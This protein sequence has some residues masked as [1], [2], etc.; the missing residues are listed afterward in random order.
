MKKTKRVMCTV[1]ALALTLGM[2]ACGGGGS[3]ASGKTKIK[4]MNYGGGIGRVWLD[5][6]CE[7]FAAANENTE[8]EAGKK[9]VFFEI[10]HNISTG[11]ETMKSAG[12]NIY[13]DEATGSI[14]S[15]A[16]SESL[17][18]IND[19][20][21]S[22]VDGET[23]ESKIDV[24]SLD[25]LKGADGNYYALPSQTWYPGITYDRD[26]FS[27]KNLFFAAPGE[28]N[29]VSFTSGLTGKS[30]NFVSNAT[31]KRSC[32]VDGV[33]DATYDNGAS[34]DGLPTSIEEL[35]VLCERMSK[36]GVTPITYTGAS[37]HYVHY[38][39]S[40]LWASLS[41]YEQMRTS[42]DLAGTVEV[43]TG[44]EDSG[45]FSG[46]N[47]FKKP[48]TEVKT[49]TEAEGYYASQN[50]NRYYALSFLETVV[51]QNWF[52]TD[53]TTGTV[54]HIDAQENFVWSGYAG[55][56][57]IGMLLEGNYW[58]NESNVNLVFE[59]FYDNNPEVTERKLA[60]MP[61]PVLLEGTIAEGHGREYTLL[62]TS[63]SYMF[64]NKNMEGKTGLIKACK[65][66]LKFL[67]IDAELSHFT[68][69]TGIVRSHYDYELA[70]DDYNR[71]TYFQKS[72]YDRVNSN[73][74][75]IVYCAA[76]NNTFNENKATFRITTAGRYMEP[77]I[78]GSTYA[79]F[80]NAFRAGKTAKQAFEST[81]IKASDWTSI[82]KGE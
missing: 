29:S 19:V 6:A 42:Y 62:D 14:A 2:T 38:L 33:Y 77:K 23:I 18:N 58:Y 80:A 72:V 36:T 37:S 22:V 49:I 46:I 17:L 25:S 26:L 27:R 31:A 71:M 35:I 78:D 61:L 41:G 16:R 67:C 1:M 8:F 70:T 12:Y 32:G 21:S 10:E 39:V 51:R 56:P 81:S 57:E 7:R 68:G 75:K 73:K 50:V 13:F 4:I 48:K 76:T 60:W 47:Y 64:L 9:G 74:A 54:T 55:K 34:D 30:Y 24:S 28:T 79:T 65:E 69:C 59:D 5:E 66:F 40:S 3:D 15:L 43:V 63:D 82:Y 53:T 20:F 52:T 11:V 44:Y 45:V